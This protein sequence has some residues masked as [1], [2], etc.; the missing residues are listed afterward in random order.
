VRELRRIEARQE[1]LLVRLVARVAAVHDE[2]SREMRQ[3]ISV[4]AEAPAGRYI[5]RFQDLLRQ[6][7][8][9]IDDLRLAIGDPSISTTREREMIAA[10]HET[11]TDNFARLRAEVLTAFENAERSQGGPAGADPLPPNSELT[12]AP[13]Q[14]RG[15]QGHE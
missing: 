3:A 7:Q 10:L 15:R 6:Q 4:E 12:A 14:A 1:A 8:A 5:W 13:P 9:A 2:I 11:V